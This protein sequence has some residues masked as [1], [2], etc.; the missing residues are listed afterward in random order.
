M[1]L[2]GQESRPAASYPVSGV[3]TMQNTDALLTKKISNPILS[4]AILHREVPVLKLREVIVRS[5]T[6][7]EE[8]VPSYKLVLLC[9]PAGYGKTTLLADFAR[10]THMPCCWY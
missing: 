4:R 8:G 3:I 2:Q 7:D 1:V 9:A 6:D 5:P 10:H